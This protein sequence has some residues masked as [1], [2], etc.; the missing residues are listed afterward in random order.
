VTTK[1]PSHT[2][3]FG[4]TSYRTLKCPAHYQ[5]SQGMPE[6][7]QSEAAAEGTF[8][9]G[10][11][12]AL[13]LDPTDDAEFAGLTDEQKR[14]VMQH[15]ETVRGLVKG[16]RLY[17]E[18][19]SEAPHLHWA[20]YGTADAV[21]VR[22]NQLVIADLKC[23][24]IA[25]EVQDDDGAVNAQLGSYAISILES[26]KPEVASRIMEVELVIVQPRQGGVKKTVISREE[27]EELK[28]K[29]I[30]AGNNAETDNPRAAAGSHC[31][32]C[33]AKPTCQTIRE[34]VNENAKLDFALDNADP[35]DLE[36]ADI[37]SV[38]QI[39]EIAEGWIKSV[40]QYAEQ[41]LAD[42]QSIED[43]WEL[44]PKRAVRKWKDTRQVTQRLLSEGLSGNEF[45]KEVL[46]TPAQVESLAKKKNLEIDLTDLTVAESSGLKLARKQKDDTGFDETDW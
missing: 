5:R 27:L 29:L 6:P 34:L 3:L 35:E 4:S 7:P 22:G 44:V 1:L 39:A 11:A 12:E 10:V 41:L 38:L 20:W 15:V 9:H 8:L 2:P 17:V 23:G 19:R 16:G 21:I 30:E 14:I 13:L 40:R 43:E 37:N 28:H 18:K 31:R 26:L 32:F 25:V 36:I 46:L 33:R 45:T 24:R 42:G